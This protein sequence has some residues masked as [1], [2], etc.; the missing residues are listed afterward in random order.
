[1]S[2]GYIVAQEQWWQVRGGR[3]D[4]SAGQDTSHNRGDCKQAVQRGSVQYDPRHSSLRTRLSAPTSTLDAFKVQA[5][6]DRVAVRRQPIQAETSMSSLDDD[7]G[8]VRHGP[9]AT[10]CAFVWSTAPIVVTPSCL[11][12]PLC[13]QCPPF[14]PTCGSSYHKTAL[15]SSVPPRRCPDHECRGRACE[16]H[17]L[18][19]TQRGV[20]AVM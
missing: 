15:T 1:M 11:L 2:R 12:C 18:P 6:I 17:G 13:M 20:P 10:R 14:L 8:M 3:Q 4:N 9:T 19:W 16:G 5:R 7:S